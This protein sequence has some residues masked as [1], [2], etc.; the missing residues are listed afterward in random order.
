MIS[1]LKAD[2]IF[3]D[4]L[5]AKRLIQTYGSEAKKVLKNTKNITDLG[6]DFGATLM[7][8]EVLWLMEHEFAQ[9]A[10]DV[11]WRR[12]KLG[13][14]MDKEQILRLDEFMKTTN[15]SHSTFT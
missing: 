1:T 15:K 5:W 12:T 6:Q 10:E 7:E 4:D 3:L 8:L 14:L 13:L 11:V 2:H 9:T